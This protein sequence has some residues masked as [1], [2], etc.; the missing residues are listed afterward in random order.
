MNDDRFE[1]DLRALVRE[2]ARDEAPVA[3]RQQVGNLRDEA[4]PSPRWFKPALR[5]SAYLT[6][7]VA[8]VSI[9]LLALDQRQPI[10]PSLSPTATVVDVSVRLDVGGLVVDH[11]PNWEYHEYRFVASF[12]DVIGYL[13]TGEFDRDSICKG[14][15]NSVSCNFSGDPV[16]PGGVSIKFVHWQPPTAR[17]GAEP[18]ETELTLGGMPA[19]FAENQ[20]GGVLTMAWRVRQPEAPNG[21]YQIE[22]RIREPGT[23]E[24]RRQVEEM[25]GSLQFQPPPTI[26]PKS[27]PEFDQ[28]AAMAGRRALASLSSVQY[29]EAYACFGEELGVPLRATIDV[30]M[31]GPLSQPLEVT[32]TTSVEADV[33]IWR[34]RFVM[35]WPAAD[36]HAA[37]RQET[38]VWV[39]ADGDAGGMMQSGDPPPYAICPPSCG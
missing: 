5:W 6:A 29:A 18:G 16:E 38:E 9:A 26:L 36:D 17:M 7:A 30:T 31:Q 21:W 37:G 20:A 11:P 3:L 35:A 15:D 19:F 34:V 23:G 33:D 24:L 39:S 8:A 14:G 2:M 32:C 13:T 12:F 10:G 1:H 27:G 4:T 25:V 22:A 28:Q